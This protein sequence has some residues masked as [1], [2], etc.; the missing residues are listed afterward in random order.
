MKIG[1]RVLKILV[2]RVNRI[3]GF[4]ERLRVLDGKTFTLKIGDRDFLYRFYIQDG[5]L[6]GPATEGPEPDFILE[7]SWRVFWQISRRKLDPD[8]AFFK[9]KLN[10]KGSLQSALI[11]KNIYDSLL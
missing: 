2:K 1:N 9:R 3:A 6:K 10:I 8:A 11:F 5:I 7:S 4:R